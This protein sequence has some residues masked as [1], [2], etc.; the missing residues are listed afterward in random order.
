MSA[1]RE[2][3][4]SLQV[5]ACPTSMPTREYMYTSTMIDTG[6]GM[7]PSQTTIA[8]T[9]WR[10]HVAAAWD[11]RERL[12]EAKN[13][14]PEPP[15][16]IWLHRRNG[17]R[18]PLRLCTQNGGWVWNM[19][20]APPLR[21]AKRNTPHEALRYWLA[22]H[23]PAIEP[24]SV[25]AARQL[26]QEWEEFPV[27]QPIRRTKSLP[28]RELE[29]MISATTQSQQ[30][31]REKRQSNSQPEPLTRRRLRGK[32]SLTPSPPSPNSFCPADP[33][34]DPDSQD[35]ENRP[36]PYGCWDEIYDILRKPVLVDRNIPRELKTLWQRTVIQLLATEQ[37]R[38]DLYPIASDLVF[39]LPKLVLS[40][41]PG[42][43]KGKARIHRIQ[44]CLRRASQGE[45]PHLIERALQMD[46][47][48]QEQ[49]AS[50][51][52][53]SGPDTLPPRTAKR[54]YKA[55]SQGQLGKA[56][57][58]LRAPPPVH[59]GPDQWEEAVNKLTPHK[60]PDD[61]VP[62]REGIAP[63]RW[64]PT[65]REYSNAISKLKRNKAADA[66]GWTTETAQSCTDHPQLKQAILAWIHNQATATTGPARRVGLWRCHRLV[67]LDK[68]GGAIRPIL[69]GM[70][71]SKLLSHLLLQPAKSDLEP[72]LKHR[73]F[74]IGTPQGGLAMTTAIKA[75]LEQNPDHVVA[76]LDFKNAFGTIDRPTCIKAL[77]ELC[78]HQPAWLDAVHV[79][80]SWPALVVNPAENHLAKTYDGLPQG[81]PLSTLIFSLSMTEILHKAVRQTTSEVTILSYIDDTTLL[82]PADEVSQTIQ[83]LPRALA[84]TGLSLQ[85]QKTQVWAPREAQILNHPH[86]KHLREQMK[87]PR[88]L[89][90]LG[91]AMG[92]DPTDPY[93]MGNE[94][95]ITD[96]LRDVTQAVKEDLDKIAV[97]P[98]RLEGET[99][100]LQVAWALISKTLPPR[101]VHLLRA[102][103]VQQTQ[104]MC[105]SLQDALLDTVRQLMGQPSFTA[106]QLH[107]AKLPVTAGGL[108]LP[109]LPVL[110]LIART[111]CIATLPRAEQTDS[112]RKELIQREGDVLMERLRG[113][114][115]RHPTHMAGDLSDPPPG[116]SLRHL[117][118]KLTKSIQSRAISDLWRR[119][120]DLDATLRHQW[121]RNLPGDS[122]ARPESYHGHGEWLH[123]LPGKFETTLLDPVFRLGMN[124]RLGFPAPGTGQQCG[125]T[126][127]GGKRC[128]H[129][130]DPLGRHAACCTKGLHT[131]RH[132][133]V[134]DLLTRL[135]RQAGMTATAEQAM[136]IPD[137]IG[138]DGQPAP[139]SVRPI[140][141][142]DVH[143]IELQGSEL[144]LDVKIHTVGPELPVAREL[145]RE[146]MT[147]CRAYGQ[148]D[149]YNLQALERGMTPVVL[150]QFG[151]TAPGAQAIFNRIINHRLQLLVRQ[152][153]TYSFAKRT[154][155]S[156][157]WSPLSCTLL[158]AAWQAHA[159]CTPRVGPAD[160]FDALDSLPNSPGESQDTM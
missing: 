101:V 51:P 147:K 25:E 32:T 111:A 123:C 23:E 1:P 62:L 134:R 45:W 112:F 94:A 109:D 71:W 138:E 114:S 82:G 135:A 125:R 53:A 75:H 85:T 27:P 148:R 97:L 15:R 139:G 131:R 83:A 31:P 64:H 144:W 42:K 30:P 115:E 81:D 121:L 96:H 120:M 102:H 91:E 118:R 16:E 87:D 142:A 4:D 92:E 141:R 7:A 76:C 38:T 119:R 127:P 47:P 116:L 77:R 73:Q 13:P 128:Q 160:L 146:E 61:H 129:I 34:E 78:P 124:Q 49:D 105:D 154:A 60:N 2:L 88:G 86:L 22:K 11:K 90:I 149:G 36:E 33:V 39:I 48:N 10:K 69:I 117:S 21:V 40:H 136:L 89:V 46:T 19:H 79:L 152:G 41:P 29:P 14:G 55:A 72:F 28:P 153:M 156:E 140:H 59:V 24:Q 35:S 17:Q 26:A 52:L 70:I 65:P 151:R 44:E 68:G 6:T 43:E 66:G 157:L 107:L 56:W 122:P 20:Y 126:P 158:R 50:Q 113:I 8:S 5:C 106:D 63:D 150:E 93:P 54:L 58:Q 159:E 100:G 9:T 133:R 132:D 145:L 3:S 98:E 37:S 67:C 110:A 84:G 155:S 104:E 18:D 137:Q 80:L 143:I 130:L 12:G 57:R 99:A 103:P 95:F 74:G 108:G